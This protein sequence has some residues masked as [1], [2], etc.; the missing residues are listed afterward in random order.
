MTGALVCAVH[1]CTKQHAKQ[2]GSN[3]QSNLCES[4]TRIWVPLIEAAIR[5]Q[6]S[7]YSRCSAVKNR[8]NRPAR[9]SFG[10]SLSRAARFADINLALK[11]REL[12]FGAAAVDGSVHRLINLHAV[13][14]ALAATVFHFLLGR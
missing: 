9:I 1:V 14:A 8:A 12:I 10:S 4:R 2:I 7:L 11:I 3:K 6:P 13:L 5:Q